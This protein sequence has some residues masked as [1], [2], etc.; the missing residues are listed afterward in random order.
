MSAWENAE[1]NSIIWNRVPKTVSVGYESLSIGVYDAVLT[2]N[3]GKV[4]W[5][6][7][8]EQLGISPGIS[9]LSICHEIKRQEIIKSDL[10]ARNLSKAARIQRNQ[11]TS[12]QNAEDVDDPQYGFGM[13]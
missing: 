13:H 6:R 7:V 12:R 4:G 3:G 9:M 2:F 8:M 1:S 11:K 10:D 5:M